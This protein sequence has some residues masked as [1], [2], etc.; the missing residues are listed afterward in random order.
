M[1]AEPID[2]NYGYGSQNNRSMSAASPWEC[3]VKS[4]AQWQLKDVGISN[5]QSGTQGHSTCM[6]KDGVV[7]IINK[8][9]A[10]A[11][12]KVVAPVAQ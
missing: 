7:L 12:G 11:R 1:P 5:E 6:G 10:Y 2:V 4:R 8:G 9:Q 3:L